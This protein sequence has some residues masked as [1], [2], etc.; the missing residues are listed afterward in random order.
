MPDFADGAV[1]LATQVQGPREG[2]AAS[3]AP[4]EEAT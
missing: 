1:L 3:G 2:G 4:A